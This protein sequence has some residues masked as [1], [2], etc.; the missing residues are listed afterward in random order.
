MQ[1]RVR[2]AE[3]SD[4][5]DPGLVLERA[6]LAA[7]QRNLG[8][9]EEH[10][11]GDVPASRGPVSGVSPGVLHLHDPP[12]VREVGATSASSDGDAVRAISSTTTTTTITNQTMASDLASPL[13][14]AAAARP[15]VCGACSG[16]RCLS[17][18]SRVT[19]AAPR[20]CPR[21]ASC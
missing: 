10:G 14:S 16:A 8:R 5:R 18:S 6:L 20:D 19:C 4:G 11:R 13:M 2:E 21:A 3:S 9:P 7:A 15:A 12:G 17:A 1:R